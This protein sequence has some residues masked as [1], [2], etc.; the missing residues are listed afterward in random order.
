MHYTYIYIIR[1][2]VSDSGEG[3]K[4]KRFLHIREGKGRYIWKEE[5]ERQVTLMIKECVWHN[6]MH[7]S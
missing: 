3:K 2:S 1:F 6:T 4:R 5:R 7:K